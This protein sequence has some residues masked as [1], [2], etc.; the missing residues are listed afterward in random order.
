[1]TTDSCLSEV[2]TETIVQSYTG[3]R[4]TVQVSSGG[5]A[6]NRPRTPGHGRLT[7][8]VIG[9][10]GATAVVVSLAG[11]RWCG[12]VLFDRRR[13]P[14]RHCRPCT[15]LCRQAGHHGL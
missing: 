12:W 1:M 4:A 6:V 15:Q 10:V 9:W 13:R 11:L 8:S 5:M 7:R 14:A 2:V 3:L